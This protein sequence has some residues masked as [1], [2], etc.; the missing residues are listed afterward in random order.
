MLSINL[1]NKLTLEELASKIGV[2]L[3][4]GDGNEI[5]NAVGNIKTGKP[6]DVAFLA[7]SIYKKYLPDT[8]CSAVILTPFDSKSCKKASLVTDNPRLAL[9]KLLN[10]CVK[11]QKEKPNIHSSVTI[12]NNSNISSNALIKANCVIGK[13]VTIEDG[14]ILEPGVVL[15]NNCCIEKNSILHS[16][17]TCYAKISI[18]KNSIIHANT[19]LGSDGFGYAND[20]NGNW[21]KMPHFGGVVIGD[22]VEIGSN[23]S[24]DR[25][26]LD[27]TTIGNGVI[28]D[29]LVQIGHNVTIGDYTAIAGCVGI[30]GSTSI[31]ERCLIGGKAAIGGHISIADRVII[32]A[33]S[34]VLRSITTPGGM[35]SSGI[36]VRENYIWRK[37]VSRFY[38]LSDMAKRIR[39]LENAIATSE[40]KEKA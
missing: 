26:F 36:P 33:C 16:N 40:E 32:T 4:N 8:N 20:A 7:N 19:V 21:V 22:N 5:I 12:G 37:N 17:V 6:G 3:K 39:N 1:Q 10:L 38:Q 28:I 27:N 23:T 34:G 25:G 35:Y 24:I 15:G 30:A 14:V 9:S 2:E 13:N 29:N 31:G 11:E 18:G